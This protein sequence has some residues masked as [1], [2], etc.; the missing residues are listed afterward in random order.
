MVLF[1]TIMNG[2]SIII[3]CL[4]GLFLN[5][6]KEKYKETIIQGIGLTVILIGMQMAFQ[7]NSII[8]ALLSML[9]GA[10]VGEFFRL[11]GALNRVGNWIGGK[12]TNTN[13]DV[14]VAQA[15]V[16]SSLLFVVGAMAILGAL[17]SGLRGDHEI[18]L[19]KAV[20]DGFTSFILTTTLGFGVIFSVIPVVFFQGT[21]ALLATQI[22]N[23]IPEAIFN[24]L[25]VDITAVGGLLIVA[26]G[27]NLLNL[28]K[29]RVTNLLPAIVMVG[30]FVFINHLFIL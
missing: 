19:T 5:R 11:E 1:G 24:D 27:L 29:I 21:I 30:V 9:T 26:I 7:V 12:F 18:L 23:L 6:I 25:L 8:I 17:D 22:E 4:I 28:T 16:T 20:L 13:D 2:I 14:N 10:I 15:F 3:G